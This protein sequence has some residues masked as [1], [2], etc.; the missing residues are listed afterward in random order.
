MK[1]AAQRLDD[2]FAAW[3]EARTL[4][5]VASAGNAIVLVRSGD[6]YDT[7]GDDA[8]TIAR[9]LGLCL[10]A[11]DGQAIAGFPYHYLDAYV[12]KLVASGYRVAIA[13]PNQSAKIP[14]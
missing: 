4:P 13:E 2:V 9:T 6:F 12:R 8:R 10:T 3:Q 11:R 1:P 7:F 14:A 5:D